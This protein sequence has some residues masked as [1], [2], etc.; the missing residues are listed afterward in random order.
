[1]PGKYIPTCK[2]ATDIKEHVQD[3]KFKGFTKKDSFRTHRVI[4]SSVFF[5][6][7][8]YYNRGLEWLETGKNFFFFF[9]DCLASSSILEIQSEDLLM[10]IFIEGRTQLVSPASPL[11]P[12]SPLRTLT[13]SSWSWKQPVSGSVIWLWVRTV[14]WFKRLKHTLTLSTGPLFKTLQWLLFL[15]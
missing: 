2:T 6:T 3:L 8:F 10:D 9:L 4:S 5:E 1:M 12:C 15:L 11:P 13:S 7:K 14:L